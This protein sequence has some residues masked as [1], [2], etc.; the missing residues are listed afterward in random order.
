M[1][2]LLVE[3]AA[4]LNFKVNSKSDFIVFHSKN[5][6]IKGQEINNGVGIKRMLDRNNRDQVLN[7]LSVLTKIIKKASKLRLFKTTTHPLTDLVTDRI[8]VWRYW[9]S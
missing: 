6:S 3:G 4:K 1:E 7:M 8:E 9:R 5:M 2:T